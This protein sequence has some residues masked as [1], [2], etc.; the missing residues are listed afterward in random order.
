MFSSLSACQLVG[1]IPQIRT[2]HVFSNVFSIKKIESDYLFLQ[3][4]DLHAHTHMRARTH[5]RTHVQTHIHTRT[6]THIHTRTQT[7]TCAHT[8]TRIN[9][10]TRTY[11]LTLIMFGLEMAPILFRM[12]RCVYLHTHKHTH[13][14]THIQ[15]GPISMIRM[16]TVFSNMFSINF[17]MQHGIRGASIFLQIPLV[18]FVEM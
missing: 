6:Q 11:S 9:T 16:W 17:F 3:A 7:H 5:S 1:P 2:W 15:I 14:N 8:H 10:Y 13:K 12:A 4:H 18:A